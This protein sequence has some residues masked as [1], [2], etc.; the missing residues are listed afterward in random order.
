MTTSIKSSMKFLVWASCLL[1]VIQMLFALVVGQ[2]LHQSYF[3]NSRY[4]YE[5]QRAVFR[6]FGTFS[7][8]MLS[9]FELTMGNFPP[10]AWTLSEKVSEWFILFCLLH[11]LTA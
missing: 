8:G 4:S 10:I 11:K 5:D 9:M 3:Y 1:A 2:Y 7:R 6:Y